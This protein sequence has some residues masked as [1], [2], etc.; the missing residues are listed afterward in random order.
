MPTVKGPTL[1]VY[2]GEAERRSHRPAGLERIHFNGGFASTV[3]ALSCLRRAA[4]PLKSRAAQG[5]RTHHP[6]WNS[7]ADFSTP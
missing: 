2:H 3:D 5:T 4:R 1:L 7:K 6:D